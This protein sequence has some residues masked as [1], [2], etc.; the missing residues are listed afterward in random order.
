MQADHLKDL[1]FVKTRIQHLIPPRAE[2]IYF[3]QQFGSPHRGTVV[4]GQEFGG[5]LARQHQS[6]ALRLWQGLQ[7]LCHA[8]FVHSLSR[9]SQGFAQRLPQMQRRSVT[10]QMQRPSFPG[11]S[12]DEVGR[13]AFRQI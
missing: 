13:A 3:S 11:Y 8:A 5:F 6:P 10:A 9:I 1:G 2:D 4:G 7:R 12:R